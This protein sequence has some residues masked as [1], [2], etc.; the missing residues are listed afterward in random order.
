MP[1]DWDKFK[2]EL[3]GIIKERGE[4]RGVREGCQVTLGLR[5]GARGK[6]LGLS[7]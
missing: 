4:K 5:R 2:S 1:I 3:P 7:A 6:G